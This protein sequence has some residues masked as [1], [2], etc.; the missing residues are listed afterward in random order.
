[1][2]FALDFNDLVFALATAA[3]ADCDSGAR[4]EAAAA[5]VAATGAA[6]GSGA[7]LLLSLRT[8]AGDTDTEG[9]FPCGTLFFAFFC[10]ADEPG[11]DP[12]PLGGDAMDWCAGP[13]MSNA[14][15]EAAWG[16]GAPYWNAEGCG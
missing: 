3:S 15:A 11:A 12:D 8:L 9:S 13:G 4:A 5:T 14:A 16:A 2:L 1:M 10:E 6:T 7:P